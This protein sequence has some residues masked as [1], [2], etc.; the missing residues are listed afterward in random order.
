MQGPQAFA[1]TVPPADE[2]VDKV[3]SRSRV[4]RICSYVGVV[5]QQR[6]KCPRLQNV[7]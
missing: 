7:G 4:A 3:L 5:S 2:K 1:S 6:I